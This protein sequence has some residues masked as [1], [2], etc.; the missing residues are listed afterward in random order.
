M[1]K[2]KTNWDVARRNILFLLY[3]RLL[4][5][6]YVID[7]ILL[8]LFSEFNI[9]VRVKLCCLCGVGVILLWC[10]SCN[11]QNAGTLCLRIWYTW[12]NR[13]Q[14]KLN[15][16][17]IICSLCIYLSICTVLNRSCIFTFCYSVFHLP[18]NTTWSLLDQAF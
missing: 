17:L 5:F 9:T 13:L 1:Q 3:R 15:T 7:I 2:R 8:C 14:T 4:Y 11:G 12:G 16:W 18:S 6:F 10:S